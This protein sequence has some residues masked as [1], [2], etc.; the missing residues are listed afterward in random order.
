LTGVADGRPDERPAGLPVPH[1]PGTWPGSPGGSS[2]DRPARRRTFKLKGRGRQSRWYKNS[3]C[4]WIYRECRELP[5]QPRRP[6]AQDHDGEWEGTWLGEARH[7]PW[8][9]CPSVTQGRACKGAGTT[10][11]GPA[12]VGPAGVYTG[13]AGP[14][15]PV[16]Y[17]SPNPTSCSS[18]SLSLFTNLTRR[19]SG[20]P[21][22]PAP[23]R[24][25]AELL[26]SSNLKENP[27]DGPW[28]YRQWHWHS[29]GT[30]LENL[31]APT[32]LLAAAT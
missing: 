18:G 30:A 9:W 15:K 19:D 21:L 16:W 5:G 13:D 7:G 27:Q 11:P 4:L 8:C 28:P 3:G 32:R 20:S 17:K 6:P 14:I 25:P 23:C 29:G 1:S 12:P 2:V 31:Q 26:L 22:R 24:S 10:E